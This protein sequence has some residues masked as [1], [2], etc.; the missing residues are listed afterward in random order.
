M[1]NFIRIRGGRGAKL[2][3][4]WALL[5]AAALFG[6]RDLDAQSLSSGSL[7][8][9]VV[10]GVGAAVSGASVTLEG[11]LGGA[12]AVLETDSQGRLQADLV[13]PGTYRLL[14]EMAGFQPVRF[15]GLIVSGGQTTRVSATIERRPP[16]IAAVEERPAK[17][18]QTGADPVHV[19]GA[20]EAGRHDRQLDLGGASRVLSEIAWPIDGAPGF[21]SGDQGWPGSAGG[22]ALDGFRLATMRHPGLV[23]LPLTVPSLSRPALAQIQLLASPRDAEWRAGGGAIVN[24]QMRRGTNRA[25]FH[26]YVYASSATIG[27]RPTDNPADSTAMSFS[28]GASLSGAIRPDTAHYFLRFD[29]Q[30]LREPTRAPWYD[31]TAAYQGGSA[32]VAAT[33]R[34]LTEGFGSPVAAQLAPS[35]R[36]WRGFSGTGGL[37]WRASATQAFSIRA[38]LAAWN[39]KAAF[40]GSESVSPAG[41]THDGKDLTVTASLASAWEGLANEARVGV[42]VASR[43][44]EGLDLPA[45]V[46]TDVGVGVGGRSYLPGDFRRLQFEL[47][48]AVQRVVSGHRLKLGGALR[49]V[50]YSQTYAF[51]AQPAVYY[52]DLDGFETGRGAAFGLAAPP[53]KVNLTATEPRLFVQDLWSVTPEVDL[54]A[55]LTFDAQR[56]PADAVASN[57]AWSTASGIATGVVPKDTKGVGGRGGFVWNVAGAGRTVLR[58]GLGWYPD[59]LDLATLAEAAQGD[60][61]LSVR[62]VFGALGQWPQVASGGLVATR[63]TVFDSA[64]R[65][66]R[67]FRLDGSLTQTVGN[68]SLAFAG[69]FVHT[70]YRLRRVDL[71]RIVD[72]LSEAGDGRPIFGELGKEAGLVGVVPGSGRRFAAFDQVFGLAPTGFSD[73][74]EFS[75]RLDQRL[76]AGLGFEAGYTWS[77]T[78]D[79][80]V[81]LLSP[82]PADQLS[83]FP[84]GLGG[85]DW[86]TGVSD[87]DV[88]H[89]FS[90]RVEYRSSGSLPV[91]FGARGRWRSGSVFTPGLQAGVDLNGDGAFGNDPAP[92]PSGLAGLSSGHRRLRPGRRANCRPEQLSRTRDRRAR[93]ASRRRI[94][95]WWRTAASVARGRCL[96]S[97][98]HPPRPG[99]SRSDADRCRT[100]ARYRWVRSPGVPAGCE[101]P[102]RKADRGPR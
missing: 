45:T 19:V 72:P 7:R 81:G 96:Q 18:V 101:S 68:G 89:R 1:N 5:I 51:G 50:S 65:A 94:A 78:R 73:H 83:P 46:L 66:P 16:P 97:V 67:T 13:P 26:P 85:A 6:S 100:G 53:A 34:T 63:L 8:G 10:D 25:E 86:D 14:V 64:Y 11:A 27:A 55:S 98:D 39:E 49:L 17:F 74:Y 58:G 3:S 80:L 47:S 87:L 71:N 37:D 12:V 95:D 24:A 60:G 90:G 33:V 15:T 93:P 84:D 38:A 76:G 29:F 20:D 75:A 59:Q 88:T 91:T 21:S 44:W 99:R 69:L 56:F 36:Q 31:T 82:D 52:P 92:T 102:V 79:N 77:R 23:G 54:I 40:T 61:D 22:F 70:D 32:G 41:T 30:S 35:V 42:S 48:D 4:G 57:A 62:R 2:R 43:T 9:T 28:A